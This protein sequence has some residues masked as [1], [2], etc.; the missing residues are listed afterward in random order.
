MIYPVT[1][2]ARFGL[3]LPRFVVAGLL[4]GCLLAANGAPGQAG[5]APLAKGSVAQIA[6]VQSGLGFRLLEELAGKDTSPAAVLVSPASLAAALAFLDLAA[7]DGMHRAL[8]KALGFTPG[9]AETPLAVLRT[10]AGDLA[11][12]APDKSPVVFADAVFVDPAGKVRPAALDQFKTA[13]VEAYEAE[14]G[15]QAG[16]DAVNAWVSRQTRGLI[17]TILSKPIENPVLVLLNALH[18]KDAWDEPF[19]ATATAAQP[20]HL[21]GGGTATVKMMR[22][23]AGYEV[24]E[25]RRFIAVSLPYKN[26]GYSLIAV[27]TTGAPAPLAEFAPVADW[28]AGSGFD[29]VGEVS[30][31]LPKFAASLSTDLLGPMNKLGLTEG[32]SRTAFAS[33]SENPITISGIL[34]RTVITVDEA[35]TEAAATTAILMPGAAR[36]DKI[37]EV[38]FDKPFLFALLDKRH[39][40]I[41]MAG[42]IGNPSAK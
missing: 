19:G 27:T 34:Q 42:Y 14:L 38:V 29:D 40:L 13:G 3:A 17:P 25:N 16:V 41:L 8:T 5:E 39:G 10:S 23:L 2:T 26:P 20:F 32:Y 1:A 33:L 21:V 9:T 6:A 22:H 36:R 31:S 30:L 7:D 28:L 15:K 35:G 24:R 37:L 11:N 18:F 12:A 4:A